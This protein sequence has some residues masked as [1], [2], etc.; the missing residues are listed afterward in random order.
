MSFNIANPDPRATSNTEF[1][2]ILFP[3]FNILETPSH[4]M[5]SLN[6]SGTLGDQVDI[7][8]TDEELVIMGKGPKC[9]WN[10]APSVTLKSKSGPLALAAHY[11]DGI[12]MIALPKRMDQT[13]P[14]I[15]LG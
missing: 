2:R 9:K 4:Y 14:S 10:E 8:L 12:L 7:E 3:L 1:E 5:L 15:V 6:V 13:S 11:R